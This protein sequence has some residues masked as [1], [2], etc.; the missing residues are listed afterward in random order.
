MP[1][2]RVVRLHGVLQ[3]A[4]D[5]LVR[6]QLAGGDVFLDHLRRR[7]ARFLLRAQQI[8]GRQV[9][10]VQLD[11]RQLAHGALARTGAAEHVDHV[12]RRTG[13]TGIDMED[14]N[15][16]CRRDAH[17]VDVPFT[18]RRRQFVI[19]GDFVG[20]MSV[21]PA[22]A[23]GFIAVGIGNRRTSGRSPIRAIPGHSAIPVAR[24]GHDAGFRFG[25]RGFR[26]DIQAIHLG[27]T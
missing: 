10:P 19:A 14:R 25:R 8:T 5:D 1:V 2:V 27:Q 6:H 17:F 15:I 7:T 11:F 24:G 12:G 18:V 23:P 9:R 22:D 13:F 20:K 26:G 16:R 21:E 3:Q 4:H